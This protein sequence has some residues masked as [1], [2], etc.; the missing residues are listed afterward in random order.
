MRPNQRPGSTCARSC[1]CTTRR[2]SSPRRPKAGLECSTAWKST[3]SWWPSWTGPPTPASRS[4]GRWPRRHPRLVVDVK[5]NS[6][7]GPTILRGYRRGVVTADW[8]FQTDSDDEMPAAGVRRA[9]GASP[10]H[11]RGDRHPHQPEPVARPPCHHSCCPVH[12]PSG[13]RLPPSRRELPLPA[14]ALG[15]AGSAAG[16]P[17]P[18]TSSPPTWC[19]QG[20]WPGVGARLAE[21]P[22]PHRD[23]TTGV[24]S[25]LG[26]RALRAGRPLIRPN[27]APQP[28]SHPKKLTEIRG[29]DLPD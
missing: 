22:V 2:R 8:V 12:R 27:R 1:R 23:R 18:T 9:L 6:G 17:S 13:L 10:Q 7:H 16:P 11:R 21:V 25:I 15:G 28:R 26:L 5:P 19:S 24:V 29:V 20:C 4:C 3:M 14:N